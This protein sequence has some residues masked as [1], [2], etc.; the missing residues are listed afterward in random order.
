MRM[1]HS[2]VFSL[3]SLP[4]WVGMRPGPAPITQFT[5]FLPIRR[6]S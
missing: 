1:R 6:K 4:L 2:S 5:D 3:I